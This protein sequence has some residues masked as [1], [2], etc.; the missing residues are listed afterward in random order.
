MCPFQMHSGTHLCTHK[1][2]T[3]LF[4]K[5]RSR[6]L[7]NSVVCWHTSLT[8]YKITSTKNKTLPVTNCKGNHYFIPKAEVEM[9][10]QNM[11]LCYF[12]MP[13]DKPKETFSLNEYHC[14]FKWLEYKHGIL[15]CWFA[16]LF[17]N[18]L[19]KCPP[20]LMSNLADST[21]SS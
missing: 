17:N 10:P 19:S 5:Q 4:L 18:A 14:N 21:F 3:L 20:P 1:T 13:F 11:F 6:Y 15:C 9:T 8:P 7:S 2:H 12:S 16:S